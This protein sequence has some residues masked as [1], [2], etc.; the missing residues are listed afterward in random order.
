MSSKAAYQTITLQDGSELRLSKMQAEYARLYAVT[1]DAT[2]SR[3]EAGYANNPSG[4]R[5]EAYKLL[6]NPKIQQAIEH[7]KA[8]AAKK[9]D[10]SEN[11]ILAEMAAMGFSNV[12]NL[13]N[14]QGGHKRLDQ[15]DVAT[16]R[17][18]KKVK[19]RRYME[20]TGPSVEDMEEVE[21]TEIELHPKLPALQKIAEIKG[22]TAPKDAEQHR[23]VNVNVNIS[24]K[25]VKVT[26]DRSS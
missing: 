22:M 6:L 25:G 18:I 17:A 1:G 5:Q 10:I 3:L 26:D 4:N 20:R 7:Y 8:L 14:E 9:M 2:N 11:R 19:T 12:A 13:F 24:G 23:P 21:I 16:Q 15:M